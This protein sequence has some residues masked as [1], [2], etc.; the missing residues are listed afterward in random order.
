MLLLRESR[1]NK[2]SFLLVLLLL[3]S[4]SLH[5]V[6]FRLPLGRKKLCDRK[7][8]QPDALE[9]DVNPKRTRKKCKEEHLWSRVFCVIFPCMLC[10]W[11]FS[12]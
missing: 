1:W 8:A 6:K 9:V 12:V 4:G 11:Q 2:V 7:S 10:E 3:V 5:P